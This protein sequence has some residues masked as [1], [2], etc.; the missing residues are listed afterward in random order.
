MGWTISGVPTNGQRKNKL[1]AI[2]HTLWDVGESFME[3][4]QSMVDKKASETEWRAFTDV[5][6]DYRSILDLLGYNI[7]APTADADT[8]DEN[9]G[10]VLDAILEDNPDY[11]SSCLDSVE[12]KEDL[13]HIEEVLGYVIGI[14]ND[15]TPHKAY[16]N[17]VK[18]RFKSAKRHFAEPEPEKI[19]SRNSEERMNTLISANKAFDDV[20]QFLVDIEMN[21][22]DM[23]R[24]EKL[25]KTMEE[26]GSQL[27]DIKDDLEKTDADK[28]Q[29]RA[30]CI[31]L[32]R[33]ST[34]FNKVADGL[35]KLGAYADAEETDEDS[36]VE[37]G[38]TDE[39]LLE[40]LNYARDE[41]S[42]AENKDDLL[43]VEDALEFVQHYASEMKSGEIK[44][45]FED[46]AAALVS[47]LEVKQ[48]SFEESSSD[49]FVDAV[50]G[51]T[52]GD[53]SGE[54][55]DVLDYAVNK[56]KEIKSSDDLN[57]IEEALDYANKLMNDSPDAGPE[58]TSYYNAIKDQLKK[59]VDEQGRNYAETAMEDLADL[60]N[61]LD[62]V[63]D[64]LERE[65]S[66]RYDGLAKE[67]QYV[68]E[69]LS[70]VQEGGDAIILLAERTVALKESLDEKKEVILSKEDSNKRT[71]ALSVA[72][73]AFDEI[74]QFLDDM[75]INEDNA[76]RLQE[77]AANMGD[78][79]SMF[80]DIKDDIE[81]ADVDEQQWKVF[82]NTLERFMAIGDKLT[83]RLEESAA[84]ADTDEDV[85]D[86]SVSGEI[87]QDKIDSISDLEVFIEMLSD[88]K[89]TLISGVEI[90]SLQDELNY[91][92]SRLEEK[93]PSEA[94]IKMNQVVA[95]L[96]E[97]LEKKIVALDQEV[98]FESFEEE[99]DE[100]P[101]EG[102]KGNKD[103]ASVMSKLGFP[104]AN[105]DKV[106]ASSN[107]KLEAYDL[108]SE[109]KYEL[110]EDESVY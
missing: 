39:T 78:V 85:G 13:Q 74:E 110:K 23:K 63:S 58:T 89:D 90:S 103:V 45:K 75:E 106:A 105:V 55:K 8:D 28:E 69:R 35:E 30:Y 24:L 32:D 100:V 94:V 64:A 31:T 38:V 43:E 20:E 41:L 77:L 36:D 76:E 107:V 44:N 57:D 15:A 68:T 108:N 86:G 60:S 61:I 25:A 5:L 96:D 81:K 6:E 27:V 9:A 87:E 37:D 62:D 16:H 12:T 34:M 11:I 98:E 22:D 47:E 67:L 93:E 46:A 26:M 40:A 48:S 104:E 70:A 84:Y 49:A 10:D 99:A 97:A 109:E 14:M 7:Q 83:N 82:H 80:A 1:G 92:Q 54:L 65:D 18:D 3:M 29:W 56:L 21:E 17:E 88:I 59:K 52:E 72:N 101:V 102:T 2:A 91:V 79:S 73:K 51:D 53:G 33:F 71:G 50:D 66:A 95:F 42:G 4:R 19:S